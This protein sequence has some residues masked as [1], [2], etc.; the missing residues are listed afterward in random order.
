MGPK[1]KKRGTSPKR[2]KKGPE[3]AS[4]GE[5]A[6]EPVIRARER[7]STGSW[8]VPFYDPTEPVEV[9]SY[10]RVEKAAGGSARTYLPW[11]LPIA[12][13]SDKNW[14]TKILH[15]YILKNYCVN[16]P[17]EFDMA[18]KGLKAALTKIRD[19]VRPLIE[20]ELQ[21]RITNN[22]IQMGLELYLSKTKVTSFDQMEKL[23]EEDNS[24]D[25][26]RN[27]YEAFEGRTLRQLGLLS[28]LAETCQE[29]GG[30]V[31][32]QT[33]EEI[34]VLK[35]PA[36]GRGRPAKPGMEKLVEWVHSRLWDTTV[37]KGTS[38]HKRTFNIRSKNGNRI[39]QTKISGGFKDEWITLNKMPADSKAYW[40]KENL[41]RGNLRSQEKELAKNK[42]KD[43]T[44]GSEVCQ[45]EVIKMK[46]WPC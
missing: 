32:L 35:A 33:K 7:A 45:I 37:Q 43:C 12:E 28:E 30:I 18:E 15:P 13:V 9:E 46:V 34:K 36:G 11:N 26:M 29:L 40:K 41:R 19:E 42:R 27:F 8:V 23:W 31:Y 21:R 5:K 22:A 6:E 16:N 24:D 10:F 14:E 17:D 44:S 39:A 25:N 20:S 2:N 4:V 1:G 3:K 38:K